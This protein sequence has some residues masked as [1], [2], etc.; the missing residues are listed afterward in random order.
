MPMKKIVKTQKEKD[1]NKMWKNRIKL[2]PN[3]SCL[4]KNIGKAPR[5]NTKIKTDDGISTPILKKKKK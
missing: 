5:C 3:I 2:R 4:D 1:F